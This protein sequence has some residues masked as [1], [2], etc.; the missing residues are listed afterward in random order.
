MGAC[1]AFGSGS[2]PGECIITYDIMSK[3]KQLIKDKVHYL[4]DFA[5]SE[6]NSDKPNPYVYDYV[7]LS[8]KLAK[9]INY[10]IPKQIHRKVCKKCNSI[11]NIENTKIRTERRKVNGVYRKY[12]K[13]NCLSCGNIKKIAI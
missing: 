4:V 9:T 7:K 13:I 1:Q 3:N 2:N 10:R 6:F 12:I 5:V 8:F 11:R